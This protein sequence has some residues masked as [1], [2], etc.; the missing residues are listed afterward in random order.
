MRPETCRRCE[1]EVRWGWRGGADGW[2]HREVA[3]HPPL[4]GQTVTAEMLVEIER[5]NH[6]ARCLGAGTSST[7]AEFDF[8]RMKKAARDAAE[9]ERE[10][11]EEEETHEL[12]PIEV[13]STDLPLK[14]RVF[15][16]CSDGSVAVAAVPG[17]AR[18]IINLAHKVGWEVWRLTYARGPWVGANGGSLGVSDNVILIVKGPP[19]LDGTPRLGVGSWRDGK[20]K[21]AW[22]IE[23][24]HTY[25]VGANEL[26]AWMKEA[27]SGE[28]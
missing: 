5:Q 1:Q 17:G 8:K 21:W 14:G 10:N 26:K 4:F 13:Y 27:T 12:E 25:R 15:V 24:N 3:D 19:A 6:V 18:T 23:N 11:P 28:A 7:T 2:W 20:S 16:G 9:A 22:R